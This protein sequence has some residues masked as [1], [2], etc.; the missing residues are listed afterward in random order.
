MKTKSLQLWTGISDEIA[1]YKMSSYSIAV[2]TYEP[3]CAMKMNWISVC[4]PSADELLLTTWGILWWLLIVKLFADLMQS[5]RVQ[6]DT[7]WFPKPN[8]LLCNV[9]AK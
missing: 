6:L 7:L 3:D 2:F 8:F 4:S 5:T 1:S 9:S